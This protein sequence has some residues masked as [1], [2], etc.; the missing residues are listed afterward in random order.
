MTLP[1]RLGDLQMKRHIRNFVF[2][3]T[4]GV[5]T[6]VASVPTR[7]QIGEVS[8]PGFGKPVNAAPKL[9]KPGPTPRARDG[10]PDLS[11][12]WFVGFTG[13]FD[14]TA[15]G[16]PALSRFD[17]KDGPQERPSFQPWVALKAKRFGSQQEAEPCLTCE[18]LG[19]PGF[20][21]K[22]PYPLEI[23]QTDKKVVILA[24]LD[25]TF[26]TIWTDGRPHPK[27]PSPKF[28]GDAVGHWEGD[29]LVVDVIAIDWHTWLTGPGGNIAWFPSDVMHLTERFWR[30]D[31]N[32]LLYQVTVD[33]PKVLTKPWKSNPN[34]Y[35][36]GQSPLSEYYCTNNQDVQVLNPNGIKYISP[37][38]LDERYFDEDE[39]Q[40]LLKEAGQKK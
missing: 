33:D 37:T 32:T 3:V 21:T 30:P 5:I 1:V 40:E 34:H 27:D 17:P 20:I 15:E 26:R 31:S 24:E 2:G 6:F 39:Y 4:A 7:A 9:P 12:V 18:P 13:N 29:T 25:A 19:V 8:K 16:T 14:L 23:V 35:T 10:H 22:N 28:N 36:I 11:G 38:G